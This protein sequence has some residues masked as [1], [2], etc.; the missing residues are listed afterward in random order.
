M[1]VKVMALLRFT[2]SRALNFFF[3]LML[4]IH[5]AFPLLGVLTSTNSLLITNVFLPAP[6]FLGDTLGVD[7]QGRTCT[8]TTE[9][10]A[11]GTIIQF[12]QLCFHEPRSI[13][14]IT[15]LFATRKLLPRLIR[16]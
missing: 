1:V 3:R 16:A 4:E 12:R 9:V 7:T 13:V 11:D 8:S 5:I 14:Y 2:R 6:T 10:S 15:Q